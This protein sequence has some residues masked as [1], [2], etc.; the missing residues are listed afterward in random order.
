MITLLLI[1]AV[2]FGIYLLTCTPCRQHLAG[3]VKNLLVNPKC[4]FAVSI[5]ILLTIIAVYTVSGKKEIGFFTRE[6]KCENAVK[7]EFGVFLASGDCTCSECAKEKSKKAGYTTPRTQIDS[8]V[9]SGA[10]Q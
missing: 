9:V 1:L 3:K 10:N 2:L 4:L 6:T 8:T 5:A 7:N